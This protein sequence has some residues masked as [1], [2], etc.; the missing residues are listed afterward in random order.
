MV[1]LQA[2]DVAHSVGDSVS[3]A[4]EYIKERLPEVHL[5]HAGGAVQV[6]WVGCHPVAGWAPPPALYPPLPPHCSL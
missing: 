2:A 3:Q 6:F 1:I 5:E 4:V